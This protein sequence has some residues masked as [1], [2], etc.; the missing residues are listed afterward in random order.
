MIVKVQRAVWPPD[1]DVL[2]YDKGRTFTI[3]VP[4]T[5]VLEALFGPKLKIY[6]EAER[7]E[8]GGLTLKHVVPDRSW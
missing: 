7:T 1:E 2:V 3:Q 4:F 5:S 8:A 6:C